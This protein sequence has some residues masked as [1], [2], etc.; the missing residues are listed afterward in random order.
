MGS[1][2]MQHTF[3]FLVHQL[4]E[5]AFSC[6]NKCRVRRLQKTEDITSEAMHVTLNVVAERVTWTVMQLLRESIAVF[7]DLMQSKKCRK[8]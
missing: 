2:E 3:K 5:T 6:I 4:L 1:A 7:D 8:V